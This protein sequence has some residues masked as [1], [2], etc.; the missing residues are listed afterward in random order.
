MVVKKFLYE[1]MSWPELRDVVKEDRVVVVPV[2]ML[3]DHGLHLP[4]VTDVM[5]TGA[6]CRR[7]AE[8]VPDS[9]VLMPVQ[10]H[11]YSPHHMDFSGSITVKGPTLIEY[12]LD[13]TRSLVRHG[14]RRILIV[15]GHGSNMPWLE[16]A[17]RMTIVENP[18]VLCA[19]V[20][21]WA[22]PELAEEVRRLRSSERGGM[23]HAC[24]LET[25]MMLA[26]RPELVEMEKAVRDMSYQ[27]SKYLPP[28][29]F[30]YPTGPIIMMPYWS[31]MSRTGTLGD[32]TKATREK[33]ERWLSAAVQGLT[34]IIKEFRGLEIKERVDHH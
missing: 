10:Q 8:G 6:V 14:F 18:N 9:V 12:M 32:P 7:A 30:Y 23:S 31:T 27:T 4:V 28:R 34:G 20:A 22:I 29:D 16:A 33:G 15:N 1:E 2:G 5:I 11:G 25:S 3:E 21:W 26:I 17:A 13:V 19:L 24:E